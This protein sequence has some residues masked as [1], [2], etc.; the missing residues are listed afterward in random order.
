META[1]RKGFGLAL[2]LVCLGIFFV[3]AATARADC[4]HPANAIEAENCLPGTP[5]SE[6]NTDAAGDG[7]LQGRATDVS[8]NRGE[9][10]S[11]VMRSAASAFRIDIYRLGYYGGDG[12]R[13]IATVPG[14]ASASWA[15]PA[16]AVSGIY[17]ARLV[18]ERGVGSPVVFVVRNDGGSSNLLLQASVT[19]RPARGRSLDALVAEYPM[20]R[21]LERNG[22]DVSYFTPAD[23]ARRG[24]EI[25]RHKVYLSV[26]DDQ[27]WSKQ[28]RLNVEAARDHT[29]PVHLAFFG[30]AFEPEGQQ[31][32]N[33]LS[34]TAF[35]VADRQSALEVPEAEGKLRFWRDT[36]EVSTL[37][38]GAVWT[39]PQ[40][41]LGEAWGA[42]LDNGARPAGL[43]RLSARVGASATHNAVFHRRPNGALVFSSGTAR[44]SWGLDGA[45][46]GIATVPSVDMQQATVNLFADMGVQPATLQAGLVPASASTDVVAPVSD[47][48]FPADGAVLPAFVP[49]TIQG[50]ATDGLPGLVGG[51]EVSVDG[52]ATWHPAEGLE[53][54]SYVWT[55]T[56][57][58]SYVIL[59]RAV[60]DSGNLETP[61]AGLALSVTRGATRLAGQR[62]DDRGFVTSAAG[63]FTDT[64]LADFTAGTPD[65]NIAITATGD[66][67]VQL[68]SAQGSSE[69]DTFPTDWT[70]T[71][72]TGGTATASGGLL[73][74]DGALANTQ[75]G[76]TY[77][78]GTTIEFLANFGA[79]GFQHVGFGAGAD[80]D[81][82]NST[83]PAA[84]FSTG[85]DGTQTWARV[86]T[87][88]AGWQDTAL[89][90]GCINKSCKY[91][92]VWQATGFDFYVDDALVHTQATAATDPMRIAV[93]DYTFGDSI[94]VS[95]DWL[96][97]LSYS[98]PGTFV[99][100]VFD[101]G[102]S[103]TSW[104]AMTWTADVPAGTAL[105]MSA[106]IGSTSPPA[107]A[108]I[109]ITGSGTVLGG[110]ARYVQYRA[111]L[112]T[113]DGLVTPVL[114][115]VSIAY[116]TT[117][118]DTSAP[119]IV[120]R[121]P[122][123]SATGVSVGTTVVVQFSEVMNAATITTS[124]FRLRAVGA[125][126]D[127]T[128]TVVPSGNLATLTPSA[129]LSAG[130]YYTVT[131]SGTV[132]D[133][134]SN[135]LG[136]DAVW[137]F[138]TATASFT[139]TALADFQ[140]GSGCLAG[141]FETGG[142]VILTPAFGTG[143]DVT[144]LPAPWVIT[145]WTGGTGTV[146][147]GVLTVDGARVDTGA[148]VYAAGR[149]LEFV[150]TFGA[151]AYQNAGWGYELNLATESWALF[152]KIDAT[153]TM[154][155]RTNDGVTSTDTAIGSWIG[156]HRYR[157]E[158]ATNEV[159]F[160]IDGMLQ[161]T[162]AITISGSLRPL[163]SDYTSP[164]A[165]LA[166][167]GLRVSP[168]T[169]PC[170]F[171]SRV[172]DAG[173]AVSWN[174]LSWT[175]DSPTTGTALAMSARSGNTAVPDATWTGWT[176]VSSPGSM[177]AGIGRYAQYRA[178]LSASDTSRTP[179]LEDVT[180]SSSAP[181]T[182][183]LTIS[184]TPT[185][186]T[187]TGTGINCGTGGSDCTEIFNYGTVVALTATP[188]TN[189]QL[190]AWS[191][192][193]SGTTNP[194]NVTMDGNKTVG[195]TFT[196]QTFTL[197]VTP[198][199]GGTIAGTGIDCSSTVPGH[200]D[201]S[202]TYSTG[203]GV[204]LTA[205][206]AT[207][208]DF[209]AWSGACSGT[210]NPCNVTMDANKT[211]GATFTIQTFTLTVTPPSN[212][213]IT[214]TGITCG[215]GGSDCTETYN[216]GTGVSLT[217]TPATGYELT[218]WSGAC[219]GTT[220][221]CSVTMDANKTVG[222][223][224]TIQTFTLTVTPPSNGTITGT[225]IDCSST[226][227]GHTDCWETFDY[228][229]GVSLT[230]APDTGYDFTGWSG[231]C[232]GTTNPCSV[233]MNAN[234]TVGATFTIQTFTLTVTPPS[235]GTITGTGIDCSSTVPGH[236]DCSQVFNYGSPPV[237]LTATPATGYDFTSW[238]GACSGTTSPCSVT[239]DAN[240]TVGATFT[241]RTFTLTVTPPSNGTIAGTGIDCSSTVPGH[242]DCTQ[243]FNWN[244]S[245][246]L[247][248]THATGYDFTGWSGA[249]SGT[250]NPCNVTMNADKTV[251]ATFTIQTF[252]LTVSP[253][254]SHGTITASGINCGIGGSDCTETYD[255]NT[256]VDLTAIPQTGYSL[257]G[258]TGACS[259]T[260]P[261]SVTM[262]APRTVGATFAILPYTLTVTMPTHGTVTGNGIN[263]GTGGSDCSETY[264]YGTVVALTATPDTG[265]DFGGW[266]G[267]C[268]GTGACSI[269]MTSP[270]TVGATFTLQRHT[271]TV[272]KPTHGT[273]TGVGIIC[274]TA[275][276]TCTGTYDYGTVVALTAT[277]DT[278][279]DFGGWSGDC[280]GTG[281]CSVTM[282]AAHTV[283]ATFT[284]QR[285]TLTVTKPA[286][287]TIAATGINCGT[288]GSDC[289]ETYDY[290][291]VVPLTATPDA[292]YGLRSWSGVCTGSGSC[293][294]AMTTAKTVGGIFASVPALQKDGSKTYTGP[295]FVV[296]ESAATP[297]APE[298][299]AGSAQPAP[300][301]EASEPAKAQ[302]PEP[303]PAPRPDGTARVAEPLRVSV[304]GEVRNPGT[305]AW[306]PGM[307]VRQ[308]ITAAGGLASDA[309][310]GL[311]WDLSI[312]AAP[313]R[314]EPV[315]VTM[316][317]TVGAGETLVV[318]RRPI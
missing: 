151:E 96:H 54:W 315:S 99:S 254:P 107:G 33:A 220:N 149:A 205:T 16:S 65:A 98:T 74:V 190:S 142:D 279:Y 44:W 5:P 102:A 280:T 242:T 237:A 121:T 116:D 267:A 122:A 217:A 15:V 39:G 90:A 292:S 106:R 105:A 297:R 18:G 78:P 53:A 69:F 212:G 233:T 175:R 29:P 285:Y 88:G 200:T 7:G 282:T 169:T 89:G 97:L 158:W 271:L 313:G 260:G 317:D 154:Y 191:G 210:T 124:T 261:C 161:H 300:T 133:L 72:W 3:P 38:P 79:A 316:D 59:S 266:S 209:T 312:P 255:W 51:V 150:A 211:V 228:G 68:G 232:S 103:T 249:C 109:S 302:A 198:P 173:Q 287:G 248:A 218:A 199:S 170:T 197:T 277:P 123:A 57:R 114:Q 224:F 145:S 227:P 94:S 234:K 309:P 192:A 289:T 126:S 82:F 184:P 299:A 32:E 318:H 91:K 222:A 117:V 22:Y 295:E 241:I 127:V 75:T 291:T 77:G 164:G 276:S 85:S 163:I 129:A 201:C 100:R 125:T 176:T 226:V 294:V 238:S 66:G 147:D 215:T 162:A 41:T 87:S 40:G 63:T 56:E 81:I 19:S 134:S 60:D 306:L 6:W 174:W 178:V 172:V 128:A 167:E 138:S 171:Q 207:G 119:T 272:T 25:L 284:I 34:G 265:Y 270:K 31:P 135:P 208:Y 301:V 259:G 193:C 274:G 244:T 83:P 252:T 250:T 24:S 256:V 296:N 4:G 258:W 64:T 1:L 48:A 257:S 187:I 2:F 253:T 118:P 141:S 67:E 314:R 189:Y 243:V 298:T 47:V 86:W 221:P 49:V 204:S 14:S 137:T 304:T 230:A 55:P 229:T 10:V 181:P 36:P 43:V 71:T 225:G 186:G 185:N 148:T 183:T 188:A 76:L 247:T 61:G 262:T 177:N 293:S 216:Y 9:T 13:K 278:G 264:N 80:G 231:A 203:T 120:S 219:S 239:M 159:R 275:G 104:K 281:A 157:I 303:N 37:A 101:S 160:Y 52:G 93:S 17:L 21:W 131:V 11:F 26:G 50:A 196:I 223:T 108:W 144:P 286:H 58:G 143:F 206:P 290:G 194:C 62:P 236:T 115:N 153:S 214:G 263:C 146:A 92:I 202:E 95:L 113:T 8:V 84:V 245:V 42:D 179:V 273:V 156:S 111:V 246:A 139:D 70:S 46:G 288:G 136:A 73:V 180:L 268:T 235:N 305:Y 311:A 195:A 213:T 12:A 45:H 132:A 251:G 307:T 140:S 20:V 168:F 182:Y 152:G 130:T 27:R 308:L 165:T 112:S 30:S 23:A 110:T 269:T 35:G 283:G 166:V 240:K 28:Q 310:E 155:A